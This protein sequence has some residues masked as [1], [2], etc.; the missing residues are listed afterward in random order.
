MVAPRRGGDLS[1]DRGRRRSPSRGASQCPRRFRE[2]FR[3]RFR[4]GPRSSRDAEVRR[5]RLAA[6]LRERSQVPGAVPMKMSVQ[7][8]KE[9]VGIDM[10][11]AELAHMLT[12]HGLEVEEITPGAREF[13]GIVV[14]LLKG[15]PPHPNAA[16]LPATPVDAGT[17]ETLQIVCGAPNVA[18]GQKGPCALVGATLPGLAIAKAKLRGV[19]S[20]G[21]LCSARALGLSDD[22][23][24]LLVLSDDAPTGPDR[25]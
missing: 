4:H 2:V 13:S 16:K 8:L 10:P 6:L 17:G 1:R 14:A 15:A 21:M 18:A 24:G 22:H 7:W 5:R 20:S 12:M 9:L 3:I 11:V 25:R 19:E 23:R